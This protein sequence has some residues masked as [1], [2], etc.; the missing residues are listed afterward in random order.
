MDAV[1]IGDHDVHMSDPVEN[2]VESRP[3]M[4]EISPEIKLSLT[5]GFVFTKNGELGTFIP[6]T[7]F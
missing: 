7:Q 4:A 6:Q 1:V 5:D 3:V 2:E